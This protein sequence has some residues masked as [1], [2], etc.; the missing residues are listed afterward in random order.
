MWVAAGGTRVLESRDSSTA[1]SNFSIKY[2]YVATHVLYKLRTLIV[3]IRVL[4]SRV[5]VGLPGS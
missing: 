1:L 4:A 2:G 5:Y 3:L